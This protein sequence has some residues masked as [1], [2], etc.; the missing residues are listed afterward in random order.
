MK[1][2]KH[3]NL[4]LTLKHVEEEGTESLGSNLYVYHS[5]ALHNKHNFH[6]AKNKKKQVEFHE[7]RCIN[8]VM[9]LTY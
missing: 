5:I 3:F 6:T 9:S 7:K 4:A 1:S 2:R 8:F